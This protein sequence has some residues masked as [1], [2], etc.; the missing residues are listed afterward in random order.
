MDFETHSRMQLG[1]QLLLSDLIGLDRTKHLVAAVRPGIR[2]LTQLPHYY[3]W[4]GRFAVSFPTG[5]AMRTLEI[6]L[7]GR[8][9][10]ELSLLRSQLLTPGFAQDLSLLDSSA[11]DCDD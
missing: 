10:W 7:V 6:S 2:L 4:C 1:L 9:S 11:A 5:G 3:H 8:M